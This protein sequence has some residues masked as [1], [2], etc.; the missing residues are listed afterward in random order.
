[1]KIK[2]G[3]LDKVQGLG[4]IET[5]ESNPLLINFLSPLQRAA[6]RNKFRPF[7]YNLEGTELL[8]TA[9]MCRELFW[10][11]KRDYVKYRRLIQPARQALL[12][13]D[14]YKKQF[15]KKKTHHFNFPTRLQHIL[16]ENSLY[17]M[18][19]IADKG[20]HGLSRMRGMGKER[21]T[22]LMNLFTDNGCGEL[23]L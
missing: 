20:E 8:I 16:N 3:L 12:L 13:K 4:V 1:M 7:T 21:V 2:V 11:A 23:F 10:E 14:P 17:T 15:L 9:D 22:Y 18:S 5:P 19:S 6:F